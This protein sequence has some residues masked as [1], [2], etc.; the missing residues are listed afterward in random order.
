MKICLINSLYKPYS[1]G[2]AEVVFENIVQGLKAAGYK[3]F[4]ITLRPFQG[5]S[6]LWFKT[7][8]PFLSLTRGGMVPPNKED[9]VGVKVYR[10]YPL[11]LFSFINIGQHN[12]LARFFWHIFD[13]FNLHSYFVVKK[14]LKE[15]R[16]DVIMTHNLK[17]IGYMI[18]WAI[19]RSGI[20]WVHTVHD[21]QLS[22][23]S[24]VINPP[25][26]P[27]SRGLY[28]RICRWLFG[29]PSVVISPSKWLMDFYSE[30]GFFKNSKKVV[31]P[32]PVGGLPSIVYRRQTTDDKRQTTFLYLGLIE[33]HKGVLFLIKAFKEFLNSQFPIPNSQLLIAG[34]GSKLEEIKK[35][36]A[37]EPRIKILGPVP[38]KKIAELFQETDFTIVPSLCYENSPTV[39]YESLFFG[40]PVIAANIGGVAE[41][42]KEGVNG[43]TFE[44][45]N[46]EDLGRAFK[47]ALK[48]RENLGEMR[49]EARR[50]GEE[51]RIERYIIKLL[52]LFKNF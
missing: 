48:K 44:A 35:L 12:V 25:Y 17:G 1:R 45:G 10:F 3:S 41:L 9:E 30:K 6:S 37:G 16:P 23:P 47:Q 19:K 28:E 14:I 21:V 36:A 40:V 7:D 43:F 18:P 22:E 50:S 5:L 34:D 15:E 31:M 13:V 4:V 46:K 24:G 38:H 51:Y 26:P 27:L 32:N 29:S 42:V 49:D 20:K 2:G 33:K 39:I 11:N 8:L 52:D